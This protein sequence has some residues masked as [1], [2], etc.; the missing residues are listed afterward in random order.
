VRRTAGNCIVDYFSDSFSP[1]ADAEKDPLFSLSLTARTSL[2]DSAGSK[3]TRV[4]ERSDLNKICCTLA[5]LRG[6]WNPP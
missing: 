2:D 5:F 4:A 6:I 1:G 3:T